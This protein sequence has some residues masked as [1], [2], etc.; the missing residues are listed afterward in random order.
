MLAAASKVDVGKQTLV[1]EGQRT[2][3]NKVKF[4]D[5]GDSQKARG[6]GLSKRQA[7]RNS[8]CRTAAHV[9][10]SQ[11]EVMLGQFGNREKEEKSTKLAKSD[12]ILKV[13]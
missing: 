1:M 9:Q 13:M 6:G 5:L 12:L 7:G 2:A 10:R 8:T 4:I 11:M 3:Q